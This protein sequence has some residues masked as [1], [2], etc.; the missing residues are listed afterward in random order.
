MVGAMGWRDGPILYVLATVV[1][2]L[3]MLATLRPADLRSLD[4]RA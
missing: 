3:I 1:V 2:S 4:A